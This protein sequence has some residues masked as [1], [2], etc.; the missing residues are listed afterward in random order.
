MLGENEKD[1]A[2]LASLDRIYESQGMYENLAAILRQRLTITDDNDE[3]VKL[4]LRLGRVYAE[5]LE[6][7]D[8]AIASYLA[9][10]E[11]ESRSR[12]A[13]DALE[14]LYFRSE[15]WP[16]LYGIYEKL[17]DVMKDDD[18][19]ADCYAR[20][21]KL[22]ADALDDREKAVEL[23][24]R[25]VDIRGEDAIA[26][27]GLADLHEMAGEWKEL[28]EVLEKQ[29][30]ATPDPEARIPIYK[31]LGR[32]WGEKLSRERNSLE[33]WQKVL[34][35]DPQD[36]DALRAIAANYK[37]AGAWEE[38]SQALRRLIQVGQL[39]GSGIERDELKEL[40]SQLGELEGDTLMRTQDAIDAWREVLEL[41]EADFRALAALERLFMQEARW[42]EAV[43]ILERRAQ[44][45]ASPNDRVDVLMQAASLWAD[46]IGDGGS[47]AEVY[48]RVLQ[49]DPGHQLASVELEQLYRQRKSWVKL[50]DLLLARTEFSPDAATRIALLVQVSETYE[51]QLG[52]R[53]SAF[54]TLQAAFREDYS[55]DHVAKEL[56]RLATAADKWNELIGEYTQVVQ[57]ISDAEA[58]G[59]PVGED[60][61][62]VRLG[63]APRRLRDRVR[64]AGAAA[65]RRAHRR[66][67]GAG[68]L[69]PQAEALER[70]GRAR[71]RA[72][73]SA[74][75]RR[76]T[77]VEILLAARRH[78]RD[79]AGRRDAGDGRL[80]AR[81][82]RRR[83]LH[84]RHQRARTP[85]PAH[86][87]LGPPGRRAVQE[88]AGGQRHRAGDPAEAA[89]RRAVGGPAGR[90]RSRRRRLQR[91]AVGRP[92]QPARA[93]RARHA[94]REDRAHGGVPREPRAPAGGVAA[95]GG[96]GRD[97]S[98]DG[99]DLGGELRQ[100]GPRHRGAGEDPADRRAQREG[101][102]RPRAPVPP[103]AQVGV[104]GRHLP[105]APRGHRR[106][107]RAHRPLHQ[108]RPGLRAGAARSRSRH[109][110]VTTTC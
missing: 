86:A 7:I 50:V 32:I 35:I 78:L 83:A 105:Q 18:G 47:A 100:A 10:L 99:D 33:S 20:M 46:K 73:P 90:Q 55:N 49:I 54:V 24:G 56:E 15:R 93:D 1:P 91:G 94:V 102:P 59:R 53:D 6:E 23:W 3:L 89:G 95:R 70:P 31:R 104:A 77:R 19:L 45:L 75:R 28:T 76:P 87:G 67:A 36:V 63:A 108:D 62:L 103:G 110:F 4:N 80:P 60:R 41:D 66:A 43:D 48:E 107:D 68:G 84:R 58:G 98:E 44:A 97:V 39:G 52:D 21:A 40:F 37:S 34:E 8:P 101:V 26:L 61:A 25:V 88:V 79:A 38:L 96:S 92:A 42:E 81:A 12:D 13:L 5:A 74:S 9:V 106:H 2:A 65:R 16:E 30:T 82:R 51:Q 64:A 109:R 72:T 22:A 29:V 57:G 27:S 85:V 69:L 11:H 17:V 71:W 14:R